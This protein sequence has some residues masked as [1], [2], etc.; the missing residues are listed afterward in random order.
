MYYIGYDLGSS[1]LKVA[2]TNVDSGEKIKLIKEPK[3]EMDIISNS[4]GFAEQDPNYWWQLICNGTKRIIKESKI[5]AEDILGIGISYQMHGLVLI[6]KDGNS[7]RNSIIWCDGRA[8]EIG[9][10]AFKDIGMNKC[11]S[12]LLNSPGNF[13]AS[14]LSWVKKNEPKIYEN[15]F[16]FLLPGD[17]IAYKLS[18][19]ISSTINGLSEGMFWD[20]KENKTADFLLDY[21]SIDK[22]LIPTIV[23]NFTV[24]SNVSKKGAEETGL[25]KGTPIKYRAG[26]QPNNAMALN[27]LN[28]GQVA[29]TGG[30]S[31]VLY[32]LTDILNSKESLRLNNFAHVNYTNEN[33]LIGK[34]LCINGSGIQYKWIKNITNAKSYN[35]MN[36][37]ANKVKVGS[38]GLVLFPFGNGNERMF[39][40]MNIGACF[41][42]LNLNIHSNEHLYRAT[43][44]GVAFS[45]IYGM[46][47]LIQDNFDPKLIRAGND[48]LFQSDLFSNTISTLIG[49]EIEIHNTTG[50]YGA[51]RAVGYDSTNFKSFSEKITKNDYIKSFEPQ[52]EKAAYLDAYQIWKENLIKIIN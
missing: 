2:L 10:T 18:G 45:F 27:I 14:K 51:A 19:E 39:N 28:V 46:E 7:L 49:K 22:N 25:K 4:P 30:T 1:S 15:S 35:D 9:N 3:D 43:L 5:N 24:Q 23:D 36:M 31:G 16:K 21:Y 13:T 32:A 41:K 8:V 47:I 38:D 12:Q 20:F 40:N 50:A 37:R 29:A 52:S 33:K 48:N 44:E 26:D 11:C 34:L 6:D 42:N 17:F